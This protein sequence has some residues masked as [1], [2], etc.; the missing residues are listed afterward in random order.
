[1]QYDSA[2]SAFNAIEFTNGIEIFGR[3]VVVELFLP[4]EIRMVPQQYLSTCYVKNFHEALTDSQLRSLFA[5]FGIIKSAYIKRDR[6][7]Q[8]KKFGF[9][10]FVNPE[11]A[12]NAILCMNGKIMDGLKLYVSLVQNKTERLC[13]LKRK[14]E[15]DHSV[16]C[17]FVDPFDVVQAF[18]LQAF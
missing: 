12:R 13:H 18:F 4:K 5:P 6:R 11:C 10:N 8:S 16:N 7:N 14:Y 17:P 3:S 1:M 15:T 2:E 9:V